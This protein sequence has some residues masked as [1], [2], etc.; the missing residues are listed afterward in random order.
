MKKRYVLGLDGGASKILSQL[1]LINDKNEVLNESRPFEV[2]YSSIINF[3]QS[4]IPVKLDIQKKESLDKSI[5]IQPKELSQ[6]KV[7]IDAIMKS[8]QNYKNFEILAMGF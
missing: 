5:T 6:S 2:S 3:D 1:F 4:F 7:I 8:I